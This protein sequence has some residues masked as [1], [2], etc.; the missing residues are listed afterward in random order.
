MKE[1]AP[2]SG[3][4][5]SPKRESREAYGRDLRGLSDA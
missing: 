2:V 4:E 1:T 5:L 3:E